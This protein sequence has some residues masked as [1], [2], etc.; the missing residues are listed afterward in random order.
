LDEKYR[1]G[2]KYKEQSSF[3]FSRVS[4]LQCIPS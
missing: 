3:R 2:T 1:Q 4:M